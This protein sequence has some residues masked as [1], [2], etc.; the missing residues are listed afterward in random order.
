MKVKYLTMAFAA[1]ASFAAEADVSLNGKWRL[2]YF[3]QPD[4]GAVRTPKDVPADAKTVEATV[5]GN[6]ELDLVKA[7]VLPEPETGLNVL[8][9]HAYEGHQWLY[10]KEFDM[11]AVASGERA[12]LVFEGIDT[13]AD[14]FL[15]GEKVGEAENMLIPHEFDVTKRIKP[16]ENRLQV[17]IRSVAIEAQERS[18]DVLGYSVGNVFLADM[19]LFRKAAHMGGWDIFPRLMASGLWRDVRLECRAAER[20]DEV[21]WIVGN[22]G[23]E[24]TSGASVEVRCRVRAPF[25]LRGRAR[26][27][28][29]LTKDGKVAAERTVPYR[30]A[31]QLI[32][33]GHDDDAKRKWNW[34]PGLERWWPRGMGAQPL[35]DAEVA[36]IGEDGA[37]LAQNVC[38]LGI[39]TVALERDDVYG[40]DRPGKFLFKVNGT[41]VYIRGSNWVPLDAFHAR[42]GEHLIPT[43]DLFVDLNCNMVR[44]WGGGVY[45]PDAFYDYCDRNGL[46]VWQ[47]FMTGC[48]VFPQDDRYAKLTEQEIK[49]VV[50]R[51]R[52]HPS[53]ALW[54]G[55]N[56][57]DDA[58]GWRNPKWRIDPNRDRNSRQT[59]P[60]VL[61][62]YDR[63]LSYLPSSPYASPDVFAGKAQPSEQHLWGPRDFYKTP[64]YT[65]SPAWFASE[66][67][68]HGCPTRS[69]LERMMT[70]DCVYPWTK[71]TGDDPKK[72]FHWNDEWMIK[73]VSPHLERTGWIGDRNNLMTKQVKLMFGSVPHDLDLFIEQSQTIQAEALKTFCEMFRA[74]KFTRFNG[75]IWWNVRDGWPVLSDAVVDYYYTKKKGYYAIRKAQQDQ[76]VCVT[77]DHGVWAVNDARRPV[78]GHAKLTDV[79]RGT[80]LMDVDFTIPA[81]GKIRLGDVPF[82]GQGM[83]RI[84]ATLD[85]RSFVSHF[86]YG[87]PPFV[88]TDYRKW[89]T[90]A[91]TGEQGRLVP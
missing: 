13:L 41:P 11:P 52:N 74:R 48:S 5:P 75:M 40:K 39:R 83:I 30:G 24:E 22:V 88:W 4:A 15:N 32:C 71:I 62:E 36:L 81:N 25:A 68:Y 10:T 9:F 67:G 14:V 51:L 89:L 42:D 66:M 20:I 55:N 16:G 85:G 37:V 1:V 82:S 61:M 73:A 43:L 33:L 76:I 47:D 21:N 17:L 56:E 26:L 19:Q 35:Y 65:N 84:A 38:R 3:P 54:S 50:M 6:C 87:D 23:P 77:D 80:P 90:A 70:R 69:T 29:R 28:A 18:V 8:K 49:S 27:R 63:S 46:M 60:N 53:M 34:V 7:G 79:V 45:E 59:I 12:V 72:D 78:R 64:F 57:N 58:F 2:D 91:E 86:L 44:V 31:H